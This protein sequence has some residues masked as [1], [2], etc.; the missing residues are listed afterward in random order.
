MPRRR[1]HPLLRA[2]G[3][4]IRHL[5]QQRGLTQQALAAAVGVEAET[6]SRVETGAV[7]M[8][9]ANLALVSAA[10]ECTLSDLFAVAA[11]V[12]PSALTDGEREALRVFRA[13]DGRGQSAFVEVARVL[14][15]H[16]APRD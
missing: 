14:G 16:L 2:L 4:R 13:L 3:G 9:I 5:R 12:P 15:R 7:A 1:D 10:L 8:S 11:P 6:V